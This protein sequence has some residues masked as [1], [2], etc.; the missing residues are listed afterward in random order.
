MFSPSHS[1]GT[2]PMFSEFEHKCLRDMAARC[3]SRGL[4]RAQTIRRIEAEMAGFCAPAHIRRAIRAV[5]CPVPDLTD[6]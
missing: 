4:S 2:D 1:Q 3:K 6:F 5:F